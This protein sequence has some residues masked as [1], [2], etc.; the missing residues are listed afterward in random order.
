MVN[1]KTKKKTIEQPRVSVEAV[2]YNLE[3]VQGVYN[4]K[5]MLK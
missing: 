1:G 2:R 3:V 4:G 5:E